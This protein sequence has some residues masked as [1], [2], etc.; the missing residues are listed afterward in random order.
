[1]DNHILVVGK[2]IAGHHL[3]VTKGMLSMEQLAGMNRNGWIL[4]QMEQQQA[5]FHYDFVRMKHGQQVIG[6]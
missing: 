2:R 6:W 3:I 4:S 1:M 5:H